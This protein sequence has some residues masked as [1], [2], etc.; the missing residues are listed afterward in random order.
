MLLPDIDKNSFRLP[1][2]VRS[3]NFLQ[4]R[5]GKSIQL[6]KS[7]ESNDIP[8]IMSPNNEDILKFYS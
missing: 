8:I 7:L 3:T 4:R 6:Y 5:V 1:L 2:E